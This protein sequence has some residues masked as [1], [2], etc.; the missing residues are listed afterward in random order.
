MKITP[1]GAVALLA[2]VTLVACEPLEPTSPGDATVRVLLVDAAT[3]YLDSAVVDLGAVEL[4][5]APGTVTLT[6]DATSGGVNL[7]DLSDRFSPLQLAEVAVEPGEY[8][9]LRIA[10]ESARADFS[11]QYSFPDGS[12]AQDLFVPAGAA[13]G[14]NLNLDI[15]GGQDDV[16]DAI[17]INAGL[18]TVVVDFDVNQSFVVQ[19]EPDGLEGITGVLFTPALRVAIDGV[20]GSISGTVTG[21]SVADLTVTAYPMDDEALGP[22]QTRRATTATHADG[23]YTLPFV[24]PGEYAVNVTVDSGLTTVPSITETVVGEGQ[25]VT[26]IDFQIVSAGS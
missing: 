20:A 4:V 15:A 18:T 8:T 22:F 1:S 24:A 12:K 26:D 14:M 21:E 9:Q 2:L 3:D 5:G 6:D 25:D 16:I 19:G 23:S 13:A 17:D 10:V 7:L 11:L